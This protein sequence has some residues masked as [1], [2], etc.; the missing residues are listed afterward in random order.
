MAD[1]PFKHFSEY[2]FDDNPTFLN[3]PFDKSPY[4]VLIVRL[5][6]FRDV[7]RSIPHL[8]LYQEARKKSSWLFFLSYVFDGGIN[9]WARS[10]PIGMTDT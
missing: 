7:D 9:V 3:P 6:P 2:L 1:F 8:F 4:R 5:S 10:V